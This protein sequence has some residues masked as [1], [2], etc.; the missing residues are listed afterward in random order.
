MFCVAELP[1]LNPMPSL[2]ERLGGEAAVEA[3][4]VRFY[5]KVMADPSL[6][7][8]FDGLDVEKLVGKQ[9]AFMTLAFGGPYRYTVRELAKAHAAS[10][11]R[12]LNDDHFDR[13]AEH[14]R[15]TLSELG[16]Q[17]S[18]IDEVMDAVGRT[19]EAVLGR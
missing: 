6:V 4:V 16:V 7:G 14:L 15:S 8:F 11:A 9:I 12:G 3:A 17:M 5:E 10:V 18:L 1:S 2:Y 13:T 19:R